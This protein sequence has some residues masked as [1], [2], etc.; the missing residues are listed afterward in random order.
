MAYVENL[1]PRR[2]S[3]FSTA[4]F[5]PSVPSWIRSRNGTPSPAVA[6]RD[7][8]DEPEVRLDHHA[9]RDGISA[10]DALRESDLLGRGE[11]LVAADVGEEELEA[12]RGARDRLGLEAGLGDRLLLGLRIRLDDLDGVGFELALEELGLVLPEVVLDD[13]RLE[14]GCLEM[15][16]VLFG[17]FDK[18]LQML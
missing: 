12:V 9:L 2:Q 17:A 8:D 16:A 7:R 1:K 3:N 15:P 4:R 10:L 14:L 5:S 18:C 13:E 6:L 11:Q